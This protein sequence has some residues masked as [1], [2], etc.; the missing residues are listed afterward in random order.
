MLVKLGSC[1]PK[2]RD[3]KKHEQNHHPA[4]YQMGAHFSFQM[5]GFQGR[6]SLLQVGGDEKLG[7][8]AGGEAGKLLPRHTACLTRLGPMIPERF[9]KNWVVFVDRIIIMDYDNAHIVG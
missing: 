7:E 9:E 1:S 6:D 3:E 4:V 8:S 2:V 5:V